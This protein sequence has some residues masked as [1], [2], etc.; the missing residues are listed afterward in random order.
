MITRKK[1]TKKARDADGRY[2][3]E[4]GCLIHEPNDTTLINIK[5]GKKITFTTLSRFYDLKLLSKKSVLHLQTM[6]RQCI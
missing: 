1:G 5:K 6:Q 3:K 4:G 2:K